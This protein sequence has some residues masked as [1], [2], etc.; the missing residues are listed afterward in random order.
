MLLVPE[1]EAELAEAGFADSIETFVPET[2]N[3]TRSVLEA[4]R[5]RF[6]D[7]LHK[8]EIKPGPIGIESGAELSGGVLPCDPSLWRRA[9]QHAARIAS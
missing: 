1:D 2:L 4:V 9:L 7:T 3:E 8:L 6:A 5:P